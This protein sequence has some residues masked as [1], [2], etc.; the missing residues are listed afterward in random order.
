VE[1]RSPQVTSSG[2]LLEPHRAKQRLGRATQALPNGFCGLPVQKTCPHAN[3]CLTCPMFVTTAE[4]LPQ[5][6]THRGQIIELI[7][8]AQ[9]RGQTRLAE[10]NQQVL[11][12]LDRIID[13]LDHDADDD[14]DDDADGGIEDSDAG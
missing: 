2:R 12:N 8:A 5:H 9:A 11:G 3:A 1:G 13:T 6:R 4:F 10:M 7:T 14:A